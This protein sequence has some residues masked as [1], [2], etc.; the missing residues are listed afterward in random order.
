MTFVIG[1]DGGGTT[2][3]AVIVDSE[4]RELGRA[5]SMGA[6]VTAA[7][8]A[9]AGDAVRDAVCLA[10][11][12]AG[13][14]L[15]GAVLWA[16]LAGAGSDGA[17]SAVHEV[18]VD[19]G[20]ARRILVGTDVEAA[21]HDAFGDGPGILLIAGTG[22]IA[23]ARSPHGT[24]RRVGGWGRHLGDEGSGYAIGMAALRSL[25]WAEDG[26]ARSTAMRADLLLGCDVERVEDLIGWVGAA[27]KADVAA[28]APVVS[29]AANAGDAVAT[30]IV[31]GAVRALVGHVTAALDSTGGWDE[32]APLVL[33]GGLLAEDG[34]L[35]SRMVEALSE[36]NVVLSVRELDP[37]MGA[38]KLALAGV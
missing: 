2:T 30:E 14:E 21:F 31:E 38:A 25:T 18:L 8:P 12:L 33:W 6:V 23:W 26:R 1:V 19:G 32:S 13:V 11:G 29:E 36:A 24:V 3:R 7:A 28:L 16:G 22:S 20:L 17:R 4:G 15:P 35:H 37:P 27:S 10:A 5:E 34:A 9:P